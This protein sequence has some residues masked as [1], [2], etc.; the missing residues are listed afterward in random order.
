MERRARKSNLGI[1]M[2][3]TIICA[4]I[5]SVVIS[6]QAI[7]KADDVTSGPENKT[8]EAQIEL[9]TISSKNG[10]VI[11]GNKL[12]ITDI[13]EDSAAIVRIYNLKTGNEIIP[14]ADKTFINTKD[15][16]VVSISNILK[17]KEYQIKIEEIEAREGYKILLNSVVLKVSVD[18]NE[19]IIAQLSEIKDNHNNPIQ[20]LNQVVARLHRANS[21]G[22]V[23]V[24]PT[25]EDT[26][27][28]YKYNIG[29][30]GEW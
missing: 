4:L 1:K 21:S 6:M 16:T 7:V 27:V 14:E 24:D 3:I 29:E 20:V 28:T 30:E 18:E 22:I 2:I 10:Q 5:F 23:I 15:G 11:E 17:N 9:N 26:D 25:E 8:Y 19:N 13:T 12:K